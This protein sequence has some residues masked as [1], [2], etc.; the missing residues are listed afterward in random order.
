MVI[1]FYS[2]ALMLL[3]ACE[4][5]DPGRV[6]QA[7]SSQLHHSLERWV[8]SSLH[9]TDGETEAWSEGLTQGRKALGWSG[10]GQSGALLWACI[11]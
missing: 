8:P 3:I 9:A 1:I 6:T 7:V 4:V 10:G 5:S 2:R 11:L